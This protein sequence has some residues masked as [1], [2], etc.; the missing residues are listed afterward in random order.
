MGAGAALNS[1]DKGCRGAIVRQAMRRVSGHSGLM[2]EPL[3]GKAL[4]SKPR[5]GAQLKH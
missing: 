3:S 1:P 4:S 2:R 5:Y